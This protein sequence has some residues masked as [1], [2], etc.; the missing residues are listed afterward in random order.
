MDTKS[1]LNKEYLSIIYSNNIKDMVEFY[2]KLPDDD[3]EF[4]KIVL[5]DI[6]NNYKELITIYDN[7]YYNFIFEI[8]FA[9][10]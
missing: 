5:N 3:I 4:Q 9:N 1:Q 10:K 7:E 6:A 2:M 8:M